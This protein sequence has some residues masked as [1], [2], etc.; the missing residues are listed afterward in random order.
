[1][2]PL[3]HLRAIDTPTVRHMGGGSVNERA[4]AHTLFLQIRL[5][6]SRIKTI[7]F[8]S[9]TSVALAL[10]AANTVR[11]RCTAGVSTQGVSPFSL[12]MFAI[13]PTGFNHAFQYVEVIRVVLYIRPSWYDIWSV[14]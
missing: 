12:V 14:H 9:K 5:G 7:S 11:G 6:H 13:E 3:G 8:P 1:M 2:T 10:G 4:V